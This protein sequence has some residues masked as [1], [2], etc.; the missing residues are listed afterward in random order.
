MKA[1]ISL[2]IIS[3]MFISS[4]VIASDNPKVRMQTNLGDIVLELNAKKAPK[5][6]ENFLRY[7]KSGH[8]EGTIFHRVIA[9]FMIQG[10]GFTTDYSKKE[11]FDPIQNE[12]DN[13]LRNERGT[14]AMARTSDPHSATAQ[15]F[16]N[17]LDNGS[18]NHTSKTPR[19][20][21]YT[22]F[23]KVIEGMDTVDDI[24]DVATG[25][26]GPFRQ[27]APQTKVIIEKVTIIE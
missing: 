18:L 24:R 7:V 14:I 9:N 4:Q 15:F 25:R 23:G 19:G 3:S 2:I 6:V 13:G 27:D 5:S 26:G 20:W 12:A 8:Y 10:G 22:V 16:I 21:G 11:T 17:V 1:L